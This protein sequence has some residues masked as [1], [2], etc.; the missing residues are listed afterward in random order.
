[1]KKLILV[2]YAPEIFLKGL[3]KNKFENKLRG[4]I[5]KK[6]KD[7]DYK[8]ITDQGRWFID[9]EN[10]EVAIDRVKRVFGIKELV[11]VTQV[12]ATPEA[13]YGEA[14]SKVKAS[15]AKNFLS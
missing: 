3:N 4:N 14:L 5:E 13:I 11:L 8:I 9:S 12:E 6:L 1:M 2:K 15:N 10:L 7:I